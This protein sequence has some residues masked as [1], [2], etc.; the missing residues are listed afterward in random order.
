MVIMLFGVSCVGKT[1]VGERVAEKLGY[2]FFDLDEEIKRRFKTTIEN[3]ID[4]NPF[5]NERGKIKGAILSSLIDENKDNI[6]IAVSPIYNARYFNC[7]IKRDNVMPIEL[8]DTAEHIFQR[9]IF[10]DENDK[11]CD[12]SDE[13]KEERRDYYIEDIREEILYTKELFKEIK[14]KYFI[15]NRSI[16]KVAEDLVV[17]AKNI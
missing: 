5:H 13:Y 14:N 17:M 10:T 12:D 9:L 11:V 16:E 2:T 3:F 15:N 1:V 7:L 4:D 6:V 8:Q